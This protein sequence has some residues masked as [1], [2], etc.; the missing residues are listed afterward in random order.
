MLNMYQ[1]NGTFGSNNCTARGHTIERTDGYFPYGDRCELRTPA[2][3]Q[4]CVSMAESLNSD[5][6]GSK[7]NISGVK[8]R[9]EFECLVKDI[10]ISF[11]IDY[12]HCILLGVYPV[13]FKSIVKTLSTEQRSNF[14]TKVKNIAA[15]AEVI[16]HGRKM[17]GL[18]EIGYFKANEFLNYLLYVGVV[19]FRK[20]LPSDVF[21]NYI[22]LVFAVR[23]FLQPSCES[24]LEYAK[25]LM[26]LFCSEIVA[27]TGNEKIETINFHL[28]KHL[29]EQFWHMDRLMCLLPCRLS[30]QTVCSEQFSLEP[31]LTATSFAADI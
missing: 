20:L 13:T 3:H 24:D 7:Y 8:G 11:N 2:F 28:L 6:T 30:Q 10:P 1:Y 25:H 22:C 5:V 17:R 19:L 31:I 16:G 27:L 18:D 23:L 15:P 9:S 4:R 21:E 29:H 12:M 14:N 26:H